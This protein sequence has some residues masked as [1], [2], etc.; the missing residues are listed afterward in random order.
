[1][2]FWYTDHQDADYDYLDAKRETPRML[3]TYNNGD[4]LEVYG[5]DFHKGTATAVFFGSLTAARAQVTLYS[6]DFQQDTSTTWNTNVS[7]NNP[8]NSTANFFTGQ[9]SSASAQTRPCSSWSS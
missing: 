6:N 3:Q 5:S 2:R 9:A 1:M 4:D 8:G 7:T